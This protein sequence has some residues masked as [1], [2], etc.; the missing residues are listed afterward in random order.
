MLMPC[1]LFRS[2]RYEQQALSQENLIIPPDYY[3]VIP[4]DLASVP[5][6]VKRPRPAMVSQMSQCE[7]DMRGSLRRHMSTQATGT[8][9]APHGLERLNSVSSGVL[10]PKRVILEY[11]NSFHSFTTGYILEGVHIK[12][13]ADEL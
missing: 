5:S 6:S 4:A 10:C 2:Q 3:D 8:S 1:L 11:R 12:L 9:T 13:L 7:F